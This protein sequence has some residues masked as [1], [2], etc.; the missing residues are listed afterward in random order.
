MLS[1]AD[2]KIGLS[3]DFFRSSIVP[4][5]VTVLSSMRP[6]KSLMLMRLM[7]VVPSALGA[8]S[9]AA[10]D[11]AV[12]GASTRPASAPAAVRRRPRRVNIDMSLLVIRWGW[13]MGCSSRQLCIRRRATS[14]APPA[15]ASNSATM[16]AGSSSPPVRGR[17][18]DAASADGCSP[19]LL[20]ESP[21]ASGCS[22][23]PDCPPLPGVSA[24]AEIPTSIGSW[25][26]ARNTSAA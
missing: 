19:P 12:S 23:S 11:S 2:R 7:V 16:S 26:L 10:A 9:S 18:P 15:A 21:A 1:P 6:W 22:P 3:A 14:T 20:P 25:S 13:V 4:A 5:N 17:S 8:A 24:L